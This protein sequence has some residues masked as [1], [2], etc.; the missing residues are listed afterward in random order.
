VSATG[1]SFA[2]LGYSSRVGKYIIK[3]VW[4][5]LQPI[6]MADPTSEE[7]LRIAYEFNKFGKCLTPKE[8]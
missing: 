7:W 5:I 3:G 4:K 1:E 8:E 2:S 6:F